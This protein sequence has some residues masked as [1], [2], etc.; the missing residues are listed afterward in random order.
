MYA[1][2]G[3]MCLTFGHEIIDMFLICKLVC[4]FSA[5]PVRHIL[6]TAVSVVLKYNGKLFFSICTIDSLPYI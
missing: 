2:Y 4:S 1:K 6:S 5:V 3:V